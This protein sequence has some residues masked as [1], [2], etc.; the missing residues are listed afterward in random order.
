MS[1]NPLVV[2]VEATHQSLQQRLAEASHPD[3]PRRD[4]REQARRTDAFLAATSR[5]LAAVEEAVLPEVAHRMEAG[6]DAVTAYLREARALEQSLSRLK[7]RVYGEQHVAHLPWDE[8][9]DEVRRRLLS[10]NVLERDLAGVLATRIDRQGS[11]AIA[12]RVYRAELRAPTRAHPHLPHRG[13]LG[14]LV[15]RVWS[16]ADRFWDTAENRNVPAPVRPHPKEHTDD[17]LVA[18]YLLGEPLLD[19]SA[20]VVQHRRRTRH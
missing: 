19:G 16:V 3:A 4:P 11:A 15:R 5:H 8:V 12:E 2:T 9:W 13:R 1:T 10:H 14:H 7:A 20:P 17:S 6:E 18:Q